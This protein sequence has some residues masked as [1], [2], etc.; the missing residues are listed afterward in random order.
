MQTSPKSHFLRKM[1]LFRNFY[2]A[3]FRIQSFRKQFAICAELV[4]FCTR[5]AKKKKNTGI[6][7]KNRKASFEYKFIETFEA[8]L[9]L[10]GTEIKSIRAGNANLNDAHCSFENGE[11][12]INSLFIAEYLFGNIFNHETR[13]NRKLLLH[14]K[15]I[16]KLK[17]KVKE[18]G[19][20]II[21]FRLFIN[22]RGFAKVDIALAQGK[23]A[24]DKRQS[25]KAKDNRR[26]LERM[27]KME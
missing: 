20:A 8:G 22:E 1:F 19:F 4:Y 17:K 3:I 18:K 16:K 23:K 5:M 21:P 15:E 10:F 26:E 25:I 24:Y 12:Y 7:I 11:L 6:E 9:K 13:R 2:A 27:N 14:K